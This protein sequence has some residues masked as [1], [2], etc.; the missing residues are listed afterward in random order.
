MTRRAW[1]LSVSLTLAC[2]G[3]AT[4]NLPAWLNPNAPI[5]TVPDQPFGGVPATPPP[6]VTRAPATEAVTRRVNDVGQRLLVANAELPVHPAF[7]GVGSPDPQVF[8]RDTTSIFVSDGLANR[9]T[10]DAQLAAVLAN[11][12]GK[13]V[14]TREALLALKARRAE[15]DTPVSLPIGN[16]S[17][18]TFGP[19]DGTRLAELGK[20]EQVIRRG[21]PGSA[22]ATPLD[23]GL[24]ARTYLK[25]AGFATTDLDDVTPLLRE[26][27][28]H[29][30][31]EK[32]F[33]S[34]PI[35]PFVGP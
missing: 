33:S 6:G 34:G 35:R 17:G 24:L 23:P 5:N 28:Q 29:N 25:K 8:H 15:N 19:A 12:L 4:D 22:P 30:E 11:E 3:C 7:L 31:I 27:A 20:H 16:D 32:Q 14:S 26:A 1:L 18:G 2:G 13:M 9:C 10:T 21:G